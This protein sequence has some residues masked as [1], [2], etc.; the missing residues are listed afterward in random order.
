MGSDVSTQEQP[1]SCI[2]GAVINVSVGSGD[3]RVAKG[4]YGAYSSF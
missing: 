4:D 2:K 3:K 1:F